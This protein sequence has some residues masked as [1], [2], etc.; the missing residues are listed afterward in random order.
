MSLL[1]GLY[2]PRADRLY[3]PE[4]ERYVCE[5][6]EGY[7]KPVYDY[8]TL[9]ETLDFETA[10]AAG[11][12]SGLQRFIDLLPLDR[13]ANL[14]NLPAGDTPLVEFSSLASEGEIYFKMENYNLAGGSY[15]RALATMAGV[16]RE[17]DYPGLVAAPRPGREKALVRGA[18]AAGL[19]AVLV[20]PE[21]RVERTK[22]HLTNGHADIIAVENNN[23][24][25]VFELVN[26]AS[27]EKGFYNCNDIFNPYAREGYKTVA[28]EI[29]LADIT[30]DTIFIPTVTG[31]LLAG[32]YKGF[33]ELKTLGWISNIPRLISVEIPPESYIAAGFRSKD[34]S[35]KDEFEDSVR[36][37]VDGYFAREALENSGGEALVVG[38]KRLKQAR[39]ACRDEL[40]ISSSRRNLAGLA[41][42][43]EF[44][45]NLPPADK[46]VI[47]LDGEE[48]ADVD[49]QP[50]EVHR[51]ENTEKLED[52]LDK[53]TLSGQR[54]GPGEEN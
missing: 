36:R 23:Y 22:R 49:Q 9:G 3:A 35:R 12:R 29:A 20:L 27:G 14:P 45:D 34:E 40:G 17:N 44:E 4:P 38:E 18:A 32:I 24:E 26:Q 42:W 52:L 46:S 30:P 15:Y 28:F 19:K 1:A 6:T 50:P 7:L 39:Q 53:I 43:Y 2:S 48:Q 54:N 21:R 31:S 41:G 51:L 37:S 47:I 33:D 11:N 16:G 13:P 10:F 8:K 25:E 5:E